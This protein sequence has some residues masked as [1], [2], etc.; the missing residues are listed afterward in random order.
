MEEPLL[1]W[2]LLAA[3]LCLAAVFLVSGIHKAFWFGMAVEEFKGAKAPFVGLTLPLT[4]LLHLI[5]P[6]CLITGVFVTEAALALAAFTVVAT[7]WVHRFWAM[8]GP[9]KLARSRIAMAHLAVTG[10]LLLLAVTG[11]GKWV[12]G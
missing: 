9:E 3:R 12:L 6:L 11:P 2:I 8:S 1:S 10:G 5:A 4:I 7:L